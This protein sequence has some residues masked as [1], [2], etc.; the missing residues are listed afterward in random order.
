[1]AD[2]GSNWYRALSGVGV[3]IANSMDQYHKRHV[4]YTEALQN[5]DALS[6][7]GI[8]ASGR[9]VQMQFDEK[10]KP[11]DKTIQPLVDPKALEPFKNR[12]MSDWESSKTALDLLSRLGVGYAAKASAAAIEDAS[13]S[14][15][16]T[17]QQMLLRAAKEADKTYVPGFGLMNATQLSAHKYRQDKMQA[18]E[19]KNTPAIAFDDSLQKTYGIN[20]DDVLKAAG[21]TFKG[22]EAGKEKTYTGVPFVDSLGNQVAAT[23]E[24]LKELGYTVKNPNVWAKVGPNEAL[25]PA[26]LWPQVVSKAKSFS[27]QLSI[28][29][30]A[31]DKLNQQGQQAQAQQVVS[32]WGSTPPDQLQPDQA[33]ALA[34]AKTILG[35]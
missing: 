25:V 21:G 30:D 17:R 9:P 27:Q 6:K 23:P 12:T 26:H 13:V 2:A 14:G 11:L 31:M 35:Q 28:N 24:K 33:A 22:G 16:A 8:D 4:G 3:D 10:G 5:A 20:M 19:A 15:Q 18:L 29:K 7:I 32:M 34:K 1:M